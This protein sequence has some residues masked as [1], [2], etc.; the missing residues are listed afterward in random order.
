MP[1]VYSMMSSSSS[2]GALMWSGVP[3]VIFF[4]VLSGENYS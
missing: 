4:T 1:N 3:A 2:Y